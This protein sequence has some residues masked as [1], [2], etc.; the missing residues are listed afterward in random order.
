MIPETDARKAIDL[1]AQGQ[2]VSEIA[3]QLGHDRK[4][5]R[6]YLA[7]HRAPG[8]PRPRTTGS[9]APFAAYMQLRA[10]DD[11]HLR[12]AGLHREITA[13]GYTASY[14]A[15]TRELRGHPA[16]DWCRACSPRQPHAPSWQSHPPQ[17][18]VRVTPLTG[19][20]ISSYLS[21]L[22]AASHLPARNITGCLPPW[23][24][25]RAAAC[26]DLT[27][28]S[29]L[30]P[31]DTAHLAALTG[32]SEAS[33]RHAL[34]ALSM[35]RGT[36]HRPAA[37][38]AL[39]CRRCAA[40]HGQ[41]HPVPVHLPAHQRACQRHRTWLGRAIQIDITTTPD[42]IAASRHA[43]R[44]AR[45]HGITTLV[46]AEITARQHAASGPGARRRTTALAT[47]S[48]GLDPEHPDTAEAAAYP[49]TIKTAAALLSA[50]GALPAGPE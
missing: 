4:T 29:L 14:P 22:A 16:I 26:D 25:A 7:G 23:F 38:A 3:R 12:A 30:R 45:Q 44:L 27:T 17:L 48:P 21:R 2:N 31:G 37:R 36:S 40:R 42:I 47:A 43:S 32:I 39:A 24:A 33:L 1:A 10:D 13:L 41:H 49:E 20:T 6:T 34:P 28:A 8:Q 35:T 5:I 15:F 46:L 9:L 11:R 18:P 50:H 19:E